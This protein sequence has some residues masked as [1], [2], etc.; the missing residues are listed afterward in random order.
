MALI[1]TGRTRFIVSLLALMQFGGS[2]GLV[3]KIASLCDLGN[4]CTLS[5]R[6]ASRM[7]SSA[8]GGTI[9]VAG[10]RN[11]LTGAFNLSS[12][13]VLD[14]QSGA[15]IQGIQNAA[16]MYYPVIAPLPSYG[17]IRNPARCQALVMCTNAV[18]VSISGGGVID[19]QGDFW[20]KRNNKDERPHLLELFKCNGV[21]IGNITLRNSPFWTLHPVYSSNVW[22]H[23]VNID[24]PA[25]SPNTDGIDPDS[26][27]N[28]L[29]EHCNISCG[30][31]HIA[32][33]SGM[34]QPGR[35]FGTPSTNITVSN[36]VMWA[37]RG[38]SIGSEVSGGV[39]D[40]RIEHNVL[41]GPSEHG[42]HIKTSSQR[43]GY[44]TNV[45]H[46]NNTLGNIVGD[47]LLGILTSYGDADA[48]SNA[49]HA[50][51]TPTTPTTSPTP[52][53]PLTH[54]ANLTYLNITRT[55]DAPT[56]SKGAGAFDCFSTEPCVNV[57]FQHLSLSPV[58]SSEK[59]IW[60][61]ANIQHI[62]VEDVSPSGLSKAC[63]STT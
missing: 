45:F 60:R 24:A 9:E 54:I 7:V 31:D 17:T 10:G 41:H 21:E 51:G 12:N 59:P 33:K 58:N 50:T 39:S 63:A 49:H 56:D 61:C 8:G 44:V 25:D 13:T 46:F 47:S 6:N 53:P 37:G 16:L 42:I 62:S 52:T 11:Y 20:W 38:I 19:G 18:N 57:T 55:A 4:D 5:F 32:I 40:V 34:N 3:V 14:I 2:N 1:L 30:D 22:I 15:T 28:V 23:H 36:N 27:S 35:D 29:I 48:D 26:S 43:G